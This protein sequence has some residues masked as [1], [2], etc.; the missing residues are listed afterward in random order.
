[1][2][3]M[4]KGR[5]TVAVCMCA[6]AGFGAETN[7]TEKLVYRTHQGLV[8]FEGEAVSVGTSVNMDGWKGSALPTCNTKNPSRGYLLKKGTFIDYGEGNI[9]GKEKPDGSLRV[10]NGFTLSRDA[11]TDC[12]GTRIY[13]EHGR[14][15]GATWS[16]GGGRQ[17]IL[18]MDKVRNS[19][20]NKEITR[21]ELTPRDSEVP[22]VITFEK[23]TRI[24]LSN[25][26]AWCD[27]FSIR[28]IDTGFKPAGSAFTN[29]FTFAHAGTKYVYKG[30]YRTRITGKNSKKWV[31]MVMKKGVVPG[32]VTDFSGMGFVDA[33]AGKYG[34]LKRV[35]SHFEFEKRPGVPVKFCGANFVGS[36]CYPETDAEADELIDRAIRSGYNTIRLHHFDCN[37]GIVSKDD[38]ARLAYDAKVLDRFDRFVAKCIE[39]GLYLTIDLFSLRRPMWR[40]LGYDRDG[41]IHFQSM[42]TLIHLTDKGYENWKTYAQNLLNHV[43]P[44]TGRAY[45]DEPGIPLIC[46]VNEGAISQS[47]AFVRKEPTLQKLLGID[48]IDNY[49]T[50]SRE[51]EELCIR[52]EEKSYARL[53][54]AVKETG[55][56]A[57]LTNMNNGPHFPLKNAFRER[58]YDYFDNHAYVYHPHWLGERL[59]LPSKQDNKPLL[60]T[61]T[62]PI[63]DNLVTNRIASMPY[64]VTEWNY[65]APMRD[66]SGG[67]LYMGASAAYGDWDGLWRF[68]WAHS[69]PTMR[70]SNQV[71]TRFFDVMSD[72]IMQANDRT[73]VALYMRGDARGPSDPLKRNRET[74]DFSVD[75]PRT[76]GA[77]LAKGGNAV[78]SGLK[79]RIAGKEP[80]T[81]AATSIDGAESIAKSSR[82]LFTFL[83]DVQ[84]EDKTWLDPNEVILEKQGTGP[85]LARAGKADV[86]LVLEHP[87]QFD[88]WACET[89][90]RRAEKVATRVKGDNLIFTAEITVGKPVYF[91]YEVV[92]R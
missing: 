9:Y 79:A 45:K 60:A 8:L 13:L 69:I 91:V 73:F 46:L 41:D 43:N 52:T 83:T 62:N 71:G 6:L 72:P 20:L 58:E 51:F 44:Y 68:T 50:R 48:D 18:P 88:V 15:A 74:Y 53:K 78:L 31:P 7:L 24:V 26:A 64:T 29:V 28:F 40:A 34:W 61:P 10:V 54:A 4:N 85:F 82:I 77:Y 81:V 21:L 16:I 84:N 25:D 57:L 87:E 89:D 30:V 23:P 86:A 19:F 12:C 3:I 35:G 47:W 56:K 37:G 39:K 75:T 22:Y 27:K 76:Q 80:A 67:G 14:W 32:G 38:P 33:P 59:K 63:D 11:N 36:C 49:K 2:K 90:G 5:L 1:M 92:R 70:E 42:K 65:C 66:R 55:A 17:G